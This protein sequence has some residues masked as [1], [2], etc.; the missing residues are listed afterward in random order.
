M[1]KFGE[2]FQAPSSSSNPKNNAIN[3]NNVEN[4]IKNTENSSKYIY[5]SSENLE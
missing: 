2:L 3:N 5:K 1:K 4:E